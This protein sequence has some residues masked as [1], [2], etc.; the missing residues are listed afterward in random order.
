MCHDL[1]FGASIGGLSSD[2]MGFIGV[3][4]LVKGS[5]FRVQE[6]RFS[7]TV[8]RRRMREAALAYVFG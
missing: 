8:R 1:N 5:G 6:G 3:L 7:L 4:L 2:A